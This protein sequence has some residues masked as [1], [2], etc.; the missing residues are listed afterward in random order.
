[1]KRTFGSALFLGIFSTLFWLTS[2]KDEVDPPK[3]NSID[4]FQVSDSS[5]SG[6][7]N[8]TYNSEFQVSNYNSDGGNT[9]FTYEGDSVYYTL[10][11]D[12]LQYREVMFKSGGKW[13]KSVQRYTINSSQFGLMQQLITS[14]PV[15]ANG[16]VERINRVTQNS[17]IING[18][19]MN[20]PPENSSIIFETNN[21]GNVS[22][23]SE[24]TDGNIQISEFSFSPIAIN[25]NNLGLLTPTL[26]EILQGAIIPIFSGYIKPFNRL[27]LTFTNSKGS[28]IFS[29]WKIDTKGNL[30][31]YHILG[32]GEFAESTGPVK[33][34]YQCK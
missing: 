32:S 11:K 29:E 7:V 20:A 14:T 12:T 31:S 9:A 22:R 16:V 19:P 24:T 15:Y 30:I 28:K 34:T 25:S 8:L 23:I 2:C 1:M 18:F 33:C 21:E 6:I 13:S 17:I 3:S 27:P 5:G 10:T 4:C 26:S